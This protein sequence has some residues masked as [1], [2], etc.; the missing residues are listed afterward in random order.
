M[1]TS[2]HALVVVPSPANPNVAGCPP[3]YPPGWKCPI[4]VVFGHGLNGS[5][6]TLY[7]NAAALA[8]AGFIAAAIDFPLHGSRNWCGADGDCINAD[9]SAGAA[10]S[11]DKG[12]A[13]ADSGGQGDAVPPGLCAG[14]TTPR[15]F[16]ATTG[17]NI[18]SR[19]F[20]SRNFFRSRDAFR[21]NILD[22]S[23]LTLALNRPP[24]G[25][26]PQ[27]AVNPFA[28]ALGARFMA[29]NPVTSHYEGIS[30]GG[31]SGTS[32]V[33]A[34]PRI[35]RA[36]LSVP[37]GTAV[38]VFTNSPAFHADMEALLA[39]I[40]PGFTWEAIDSSSP[41]FNKAIAA[42]YLQVISV[43]KWILDPGDP[44]NYASSLVHVGAGMADFLTDPSF[45]TP[46]DPKEIHGQV[47]A[48]DQVVPNP[49]NWLLLELIG[50]TTTFYQ[51]GSAP[52]GAVSHG[53]LATIPQVQAD[54]AGFLF[55]GVG[56]NNTVTLP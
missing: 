45:A 47:A 52:D 4:L 41:T 40:I 13:F 15:V 35:S 34:N 50:G 32:A 55:T 5:K 11:C 39:S 9:G 23:A 48:L 16:S 24:P 22:V 36:L 1:V 3:G 46:Q 44:I 12:G 21:Q 56:T 38:D 31:I 53:M 42:A 2:L 29:V 26:F 14:G 19:Y 18:P 10:G 37:G 27:P 20:V 25:L 43:A 28:Q 33:A 8:N 6:E 49:E 17:A 51:S 7:T 30:L 54:A